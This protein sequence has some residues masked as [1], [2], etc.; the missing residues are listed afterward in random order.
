MPTNLQGETTPET[1][2]FTDKSPQICKRED[3]PEE[4]RGFPQ[5]Q[6]QRLPDQ[7]LARYPTNSVFS[8]EACSFERFADS[9]VISVPKLFLLEF[10]LV[11]ECLQN[12]NRASFSHRSLKICI[13]TQLEDHRRRPV[14]VLG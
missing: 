6:L 2:I 10:R 4:A 13:R 1:T 7:V 11:R 5:K 9:P 14:G 8:A 3:G 12:R